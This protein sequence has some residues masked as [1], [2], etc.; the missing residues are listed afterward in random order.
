MSPETQEVTPQ[1]DPPRLE[2]EEIAS[3]S[4]L[5]HLE[6]L[7]RTLV[8]MGVLAVAATCG[9]WFVSGQILELLVTPDLGQVHYFGPTEGFM[10]RFK[11]SLVV[12]LM[13][14]F[15]LLL[16]QLWRFVSPG[17]FHRERRAV[18]PV[19]VSSTA[20]FYAGVAFA[21]V[22]VV[23]KTVA[24]FMSFAGDALQP[25]I[26]VTQYFGFVSRFCLA[27]GVVFQLPLVI[28]LLAALGI[29]SPGRLWRTWRYG[30]IAIFVTS[31]WLTPPDV[32]S[33]VMLGVPVV[34]LYVASMLLAVV[35]ARRRRKGDRAG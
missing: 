4:F 21:Y 23:P 12:G 24:F 3:M 26:N 32:V 7:R 22:G 19:L 14:A 2:I 8:V 34:V 11:V 29:V 20:L 33:Q 17:L 28:V 18:I 5:E 31:A 27:F 1:P 35:F 10:I 30:I 13:V 6:E 16:W 9:A 15:P 25:M